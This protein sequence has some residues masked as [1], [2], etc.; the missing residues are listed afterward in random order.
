VEREGVRYLGQSV[1]FVT[2]TRLEELRSFLHK[3]AVDHVVVEA[4]IGGLV[5]C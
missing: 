1:L 5:P 2:R 3:E 4:S